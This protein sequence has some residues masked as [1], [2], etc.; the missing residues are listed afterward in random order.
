MNE[1][2]S[3]IICFDYQYKITFP[4]QHQVCIVCYQNFLHYNITTCPICRYPIELELQNVEESGSTL[5][6]NEDNLE[7]HID[8]SD[9]VQLRI[10]DNER[11]SRTSVRNFAA[12]TCCCLII[13]FTGIYAV[14]TMTKQ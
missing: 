13:L 7:E 1:N 10:D 3:C 14:L 5:R 6:I 11:E 4:C 8:I 12:S 9:T 2:D